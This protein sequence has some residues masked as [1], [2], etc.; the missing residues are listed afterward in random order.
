MRR[1]RKPHP[2]FD[3]PGEADLVGRICEILAF[4]PIEVNNL[5]SRFATM[6]NQVVRNNEHTPFC[7]D[8]RNDGSFKKWL[9]A[10]G[11]KVGPLFE[12]NRSLVYLPQHQEDQRQKVLENF[13]PDDREVPRCRLQ[14][15]KNGGTR[16]RCEYTTVRNGEAQKTLNRRWEVKQDAEP[17]NQLSMLMAAACFL[18]AP[19]RV[20]PDASPTRSE[21][22]ES[23][24]MTQMPSE[25]EPEQCESANDA[26][27]A[28]EEDRADDG[29][30][31]EQATLYKDSDFSEQQDGPEASD[32]SD[33]AENP[34]VWVEV[35][36]AFEELDEEDFVMIGDSTWEE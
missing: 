34:A 27:A 8:K 21:A 29:D 32:E 4:N 10:C 12:R 14:R 9:L 16:T 7:P 17:Q 13:A 5:S 23:P 18:A 11:F 2:A 30:G 33:C 26:D 1:D 36:P 24:E 15:A 19:P 20:S 28:E 31:V 3:V 6:F 22:G 35:L 25:P